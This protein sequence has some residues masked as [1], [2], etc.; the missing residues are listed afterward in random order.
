MSKTITITYRELAEKASASYRHGEVQE[1]IL[2]HVDQNNGDCGSI[3]AD[4]VLH[5]VNPTF[6]VEVNGTGLV[7]SF[8]MW[9]YSSALDADHIGSLISILK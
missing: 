7:W 9:E 8:G 3:R 6:T 5:L 4:R 2:N 1:S